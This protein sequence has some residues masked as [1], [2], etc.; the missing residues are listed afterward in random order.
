MKPSSMTYFIDLKMETI[1]AWSYNL[2]FCYHPILRFLF[3]YAQ[4]YSYSVTAFHANCAG[5]DY[6]LF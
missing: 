1:Y 6:P 2:F 5:L 3:F 4:V